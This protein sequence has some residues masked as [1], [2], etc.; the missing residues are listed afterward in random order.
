MLFSVLNRIRAAR[1]AAIAA[2]SAALLLIGSSA[3]AAPVQVSYGI[4]GGTINLGG[5][6]INVTAGTYNVLYAGGAPT[7]G[8]TLSSGAFSLTGLGFQ[9]TQPLNGSTVFGLLAP[10]TGILSAGLVGTGAINA[11]LPP[12]FLLSGNL[13]LAA[14]PPGGGLSAAGL[15]LGTFN[16]TL[17]AP[18]AFAVTGI[19]LSRTVVP[20][21]STAWLLGLG[22]AGLAGFTRA[23]ARR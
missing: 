16:A 20:E 18:F 2:A 6:N 8:G 11:P 22:L 14:S 21:P 3:S 19:E 4:T 15:V 10:V 1:F 12:S 7:V 9:I 13:T 23:R 5:P 17:I